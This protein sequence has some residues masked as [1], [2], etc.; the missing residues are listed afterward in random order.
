MKTSTTLLS[1]LFISIPITMVAFNWLLIN[2][3]NEGNLTVRWTPPTHDTMELP[4]FKHVVMDGRLHHSKGIQSINGLLLDFAS[5]PNQKPLLLIPDFL[6]KNVI[7]KVINDTLYISYYKEHMQEGVLWDWNSYHLSLYGSKINSLTLNYGSYLITHLATD[8]LRL[9]AT[10][11]DVNVNNLTATTLNI[12]A[13]GSSAVHLYANNKVEQLEYSIH[14][15]DGKL[16]IQP[17][18]AR[19]YKPGDV[20]PD[21]Q[22]VLIGKAPEMQKYIT[23]QRSG[24]PDSD[25]ALIK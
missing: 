5:Y 15:K 21:A 18:A 20:H 6:R 3:Y 9:Q 13:H 16:E 19:S 11:A 4:A 24:K 22:L 10:N 8:S 1:I 17:D 12:T 23:H 7:T 2:E 14:D 25:D